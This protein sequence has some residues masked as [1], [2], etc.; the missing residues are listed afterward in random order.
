MVYFDKNLNMTKKPPTIETLKE[1][2]VDSS[3]LPQKNLAH[4]YTLK[5]LT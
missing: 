5:D 2:S 4:D 3:V 1:E